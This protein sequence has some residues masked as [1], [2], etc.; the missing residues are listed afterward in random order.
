MGNGISYVCGLDNKNIKS[1][2]YCCKTRLINLNFLSGD[3]FILNLKKQS[4][5]LIMGKI[6]IIIR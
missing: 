4:L 3:K 2:N 1:F 5:D 6:Y